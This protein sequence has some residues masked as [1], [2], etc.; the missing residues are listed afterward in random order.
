MPKHDTNSGAED[1]RLPKEFPGIIP[2]VDPLEGFLPPRKV[3]GF[4]GQGRVFAPPGFLR[5]GEK[6]KTDKLPYPA[7]TPLP[8]PAPIENYRGSGLVDESGY[9]TR[10]RYG[11]VDKLVNEIFIELTKITDFS[12]RLSIYKELKRLGYY[13]RG[14]I[15]AAVKNG[16]AVYGDAEA[17]AFGMFLESANARGITWQRMLAEDARLASVVSSGPTVRV[18]PIEDVVRALVN[19]FLSQY[20]R[21]PTAAELKAGIPSIQKMERT[22]VGKGQQM[23]S[24]SATARLQ[25][26]KANPAEAGAYAAGMGLN[27]IFALLGRG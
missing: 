27:R 6:N 16:S 26:G 4:S 25:A 7:R 17:Q 10:G 22:A 12:A 14:D 2:P 11:A 19:E 23:P 13:G 8:R 24:L 1:A 20:G 18:S 21:V 3:I 5:V 9:V 15:S